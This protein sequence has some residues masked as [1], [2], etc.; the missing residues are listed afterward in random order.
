MTHSLTRLL[1]TTVS[2]INLT[3]MG[4]SDQSPPPLPKVGS[5]TATPETTAKADS[6]AQATHSEQRLRERA[7]AYLEALRINDLAS[8]Y[9]LD[10]GSLDGTLTP[11]VFRDS[12]IP[13]TGSLLSYT[14][15]SVSLQGDDAHVEAEV[16]F[17]LP[18][19]RKPYE[20]KMA[21]HWVTKNGD[22]FHKLQQASDVQPRG[23]SSPTSNA[24]VSKGPSGAPP[25]KSH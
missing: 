20:T 25:L 22:F 17:Q 14:I 5:S 3:L 13:L 24:G 18:Q 23:N 19:L 15:T 8:A 12:A 9:R 11:L 10:A 2:L 21:M 4:C 1:L 7:N 6:P 16:S